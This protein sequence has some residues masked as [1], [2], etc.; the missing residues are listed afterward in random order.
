MKALT[1]EQVE[2][3]KGKAVRFLENVL[4]D[5]ER[6]DEVE[7]ESIESYAER[8][9]IQIVNPRRGKQIMATKQ[10]LEQEIRELEDE[11]EE[12]NQRLDEVLDIVA[13]PEEEGQEEELEG[14]EL[15]E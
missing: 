15:G 8:R 2:A 12:L 1:R 7:A 10:Q 4:D 6:A 3:R 11:N 9:G 14:E 13:P 5:P